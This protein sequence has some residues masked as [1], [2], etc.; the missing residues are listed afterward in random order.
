[1]LHPTMAM[2]NANEYVRENRIK[3]LTYCMEDSS[4]VLAR[5]PTERAIF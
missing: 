4:S 2:Y 5:T 1:M 3:L